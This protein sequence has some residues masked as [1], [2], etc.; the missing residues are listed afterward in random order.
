MT[1]FIQVPLSILSK[2]WAVQPSWME[3]GA[4]SSCQDY[5][6]SIT[7]WQIDEETMETV[8]DFIFWGSKIMSFYDLF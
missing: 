3:R 4:E 6:D 5:I 1:E 7:S 2:L 8:S